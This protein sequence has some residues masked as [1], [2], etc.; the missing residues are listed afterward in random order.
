MKS[1][2]KKTSSP[3]RKKSRV[4][5]TVLHGKSS[6]NSLRSVNSVPQMKLQTFREAFN[7]I[8]QD[9]DG[10]ISKGKQFIF[11]YFTRYLLEIVL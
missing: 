4:S 8:D 1:A 6:Q 11:C 2:K 5:L 7:V 9:G 3:G 10:S